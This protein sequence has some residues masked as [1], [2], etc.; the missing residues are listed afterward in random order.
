MISIIYT[1]STSAAFEWNNDLPYYLGSNFV[2]RVDGRE[3]YSGSTN[4]FSAFD[5]LP[6]REYV[7]TVDEIG[8]AHV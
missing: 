1:S 2:A 4:V 3:V 7:L 6:D 5:L 8:R